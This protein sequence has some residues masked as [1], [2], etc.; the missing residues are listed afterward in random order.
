MR[1]AKEK[2]DEWDIV[3][4]VDNEDPEVRGDGPE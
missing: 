1:E 3:D 2:D 4:M